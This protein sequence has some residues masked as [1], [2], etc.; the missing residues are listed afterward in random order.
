MRAC[1][2]VRV[3]VWVCLRLFCVFAFV[4]A[5]G[6]LRVLGGEVCVLAGFDAPAA[7]QRLACGLAHHCCR[8]SAGDSRALAETLAAVVGRLGLLDDPEIVWELLQR[9]DDLWKS[10]WAR[11]SSAVDDAYRRSSDGKRVLSAFLVRDCHARAC[12][13][14][15]DVR[16]PRG[17]VRHCARALCASCPRC[18]FHPLSIVYCQMFF[19]GVCF[20]GNLTLG[21]TC[22]LHGFLWSVSV[23]VRARDRFVHG[24]CVLTVLT[25]VSVSGAPA[26]RRSCC[27]GYFRQVRVHMLQRQRVPIQRHRPGALGEGHVLAEISEGHGRERPH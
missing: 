9:D 21:W 6:A 16:E 8:L 1:A 18:S 13:D 3:S 4:R 20:L 23:R 17:L 7:C 12:N 22:V 10:V 14:G 26:A 15:H 25:A 2:R 5:P 11:L 27:S 24:A 19:R